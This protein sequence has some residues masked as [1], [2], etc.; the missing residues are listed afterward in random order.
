MTL[1]E[2]IA[3]SGSVSD[4]AAWLADPDGTGTES[5]AFLERSL[6]R[7]PPAKQ[8]QVIA[9]IQ[10]GDQ[11]ETDSVLHELMIHEACHLLNLDPTFQPAIDD[12]TPDLELRAAGV[13]YIAD[14]F[15]TNR[16]VSTLR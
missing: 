15:I 13:A 12:L 8:K 10:A 6:S 14:V 3:R 1:A 11:S 5:M 16:P 4:L 9:R 2:T 7:V